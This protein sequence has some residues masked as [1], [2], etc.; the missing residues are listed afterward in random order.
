MKT[1]NLYVTGGHS[2]L[3]EKLT[4][5]EYAESQKKSEFVQYKICIDY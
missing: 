1:N 4:S 5:I 2:I 3:V